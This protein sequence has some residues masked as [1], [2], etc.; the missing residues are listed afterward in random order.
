[1]AYGLKY[2]VGFKDYHLDILE[3]GYTGD[4]SAV[5][6]GNPAV[7]HSWDKDEPTAPVRGSSIAAN[8]IGIPLLTFY[9]DNDDQFEGQL[10]Q[11]TT[12]I[13]TGFLV[14]DDC[15]EDVDDLE[16]PVSLSFTDNLGLLSDVGFGEALAQRITVNMR[17]ALTS[18]GST[19]NIAH[20]LLPGDEITIV[21]GS[22]FPP[23]F[24]IDTVI[25][26]DS[27]TTTAPIGTLSGGTYLVAIKQVLTASKI[28][29]FSVIQA[30]LRMTGIDLE[31][32]IFAQL[33]ED[34]QNTTYS[35]LEQ[36]YI[37]RES[38]L[39]AE[40]EYDNCF[41]VLET[42]LTRLQMTLM[43]AKGRWTL[44]RWFEFN[45]TGFFYNE[46]YRLIQSLVTYT[47][48]KVSGRNQAIY[49]EHGYNKRIFRPFN[50]VKETFNYQLPFQLLKNSDLQEL[51]PLRTSYAQGSNTVYEYDMPHWSPVPA[52]T[53]DIFIRVVKDSVDNEIE[54]YMVVHFEQAQSEPI[55]GNVGDIIEFSFQMRTALSVP[56]TGNIVMQVR[57]ENGTDTYYANNDG[58]WASNGGYPI[59]FVQDLQTWQN[60]T[61]KTG[62]LPFDGLVSIIL[63]DK[64]T[65][66]TDPDAGTYY[67]DLSFIY[68][69]FINQSTKIIGQTHTNTQAITI[70]NN[71]DDEIRMDDSPRNYVSGTLFLGSLTGLLQTRTA[72]WNGGQRLGQV[73]T[74]EVKQWRSRAR[75][76]LE[77]NLHGEMD[78][79]PLT[80]FTNPAFPNL[81][82][83]PGRMEI[84]YGEKKMTCALHELYESGE[85]AVVSTYNFQYIY[86]TK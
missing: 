38:F 20:T 52:V 76:I 45:P 1:M 35:F 51:G 12:L 55:E 11:N 78:V 27:Y 10:Y 77:G 2:T 21:D 54:R 41:A 18:S 30:C 48:F 42:V 50:Y 64:S 3:K 16:H 73:T 63:N 34:S 9:A 60:F 85:S 72:L 8:I 69:S 46:D 19:L 43:Q 59:Q 62:P 44:I 6:A 36:T 15:N 74:Q 65:N 66:P 37:S 83:I 26:A 17:I 23:T 84:D 47:Q 32:N 53:G 29:L 7:V 31:M 56:A 40:R 39:K 82:F 25:D 68:T 49:P 61:V 79:S 5:L 4:P 67:N 86:N 28:S 70:K 71:A 22:S 81:N 14:Q 80:T 57:I 75:T 13:F 33:K 58:T 24:I